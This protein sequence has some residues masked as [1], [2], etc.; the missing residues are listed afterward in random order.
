MSDKTLV[1]LNG[2]SNEVPKPTPPVSPTPPVDALKKSVEKIKKPTANL[3]KKDKALMGVAG[4]SAVGTGVVGYAFYGIDGKGNPLPVVQ[5][6]LVKQNATLAASTND[7]MG[8]KQAFDSARAEVGPGSYFEWRGQVYNTYTEAEWTQMTPEQQEQYVSSLGDAA[9]SSDGPIYHEPVISAKEPVVPVEAQVIDGP[10]TPV[11]PAY[12]PS[13]AASG[14]LPDSLNA[15][16]V[17][18]A[19]VV[20]ISQ[21][22]VVDGIVLNMDDDA[23]VEGVIYDYNNDQ[24]FDAVFI[25]TNDD[26][27][28]DMG[29]QIKPNGEFGPW[30]ALDTPIPMPDIEQFSSGGNN[31]G[32]QPSTPGF[33]P[34][35]RDIKPDDVSPKPQLTKQPTEYTQSGSDA[36]RLRDSIVDSPTPVEE[37][38]YYDNYEPPV[39]DLQ[40]DSIDSTYEDT[41]WG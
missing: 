20:D 8:F 28:L 30:I 24:V 40:N 12:N 34:E 14:T 21:D 31:L 3:T 13:D 37:D 18:D 6:E 1:D 23:A 17:K 32:T 29:S 19:R 22:G 5:P 36:H 33:V 4:V 7:N 15:L 41:S 11:R 25:D 27:A 9:G 2:S 10:S 16:E 35:E 38:M 39:D 26:N